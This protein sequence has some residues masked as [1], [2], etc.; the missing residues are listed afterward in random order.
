MPKKE[1]TEQASG[2]VC[3]ALYIMLLYMKT[4]KTQYCPNSFFNGVFYLLL[5]ISKY[6]QPLARGSVRMYL[7]KSGFA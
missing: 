6:L 3:I 5:L 1:L 4:A 2:S 7:I